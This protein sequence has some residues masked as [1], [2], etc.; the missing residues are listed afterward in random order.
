V[1]S[2][3]NPIAAAIFSIFGVIGGYFV[4]FVKLLIP[5]A[6]EYSGNIA[7]S[8]YTTTKTLLT[9]IIDNIQSIKDLQTKLGRDITVKELLVELDKSLDT[10][11]KAII[12]KI[13]KDLGY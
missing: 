5:R 3:S 12:D 4:K 11:E 1:L 7:T 10:N 8:A 2:E 13:K 6:I 9:K